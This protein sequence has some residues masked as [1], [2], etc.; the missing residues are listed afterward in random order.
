[1]FWNPVFFLTFI[2]TT[3]LGLVSVKSHC[4]LS[5]FEEFRRI[6]T[7]SDNDRNDGLEFP[8]Y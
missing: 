3:S 8:L 1:M 2:L 6:G 4:D 5:T 7:G